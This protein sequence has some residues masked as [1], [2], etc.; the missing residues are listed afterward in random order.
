M[1]LDEP[2]FARAASSRIKA[3]ISSAIDSKRG[4]LSTR[5]LE[6]Y[7]HIE[8]GDL[9]TSKQIMA[10]ATTE[11]WHRVFVDPPHPRPA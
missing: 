4:Y 3:L 6:K 9:L 1:P 10:V 2:T 8:T 7:L 5:E 11:A